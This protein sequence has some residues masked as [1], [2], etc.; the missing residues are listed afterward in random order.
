V[1]QVNL[2]PDIIPKVK[3]S[4]TLEI[5]GD[6]WLLRNAVCLLQGALFKKSSGLALMVSKQINRSYFGAQ[7]HKIG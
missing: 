2:F 5:R 7:L 6:F 1:V 4:S 3:K